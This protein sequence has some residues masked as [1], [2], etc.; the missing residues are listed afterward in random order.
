[1]EVAHA[2]YRVETAP[3]RRQSWVEGAQSR[4]KPCG[5]MRHMA[6]QRRMLGAQGVR[7][8]QRF[9]TRQQQHMHA[10]LRV[11]IIHDHHMVRLH[12]HTVRTRVGRARQPLERIETLVA[13]GLGRLT[14]ALQGTILPAGIFPLGCPQTAALLHSLLWMPTAPPLERRRCQ[15]ECDGLQQ[16]CI[17]CLR[18]LQRLHRPC[19]CRYRCGGPL[20]CTLLPRRQPQLH[21]TSSLGERLCMATHD[22]AHLADA[23]IGLGGK[24]DAVSRTAAAQCSEHRPAACPE[25]R[26]RV[27]FLPVKTL[28]GTSLTRIGHRNEHVKR[29]SIG[30]RDGGKGLL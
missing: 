11:D 19:G 23:G 21:G 25:Q 8:T 18:P 17:R 4:R 20:V 16:S 3:Q 30:R 7:P 24:M 27:S 2:R 5:E 28:G 22:C 29:A 6:Q 14:E 1:M 10:C 13:A 26:A 15:L 9:V 12:Q